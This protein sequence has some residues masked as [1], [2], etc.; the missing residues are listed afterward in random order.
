MSVWSVKKLISKAQADVMKSMRQELQ[1]TEEQNGVRFERTQESMRSMMNKVADTRKTAR[2]LADAAQA[3]AVEI[4]QNHA[5]AAK[6]EVMKTA[7]EE[8][9]NLRNDIMKEV[10]SMHESMR[11]VGPP[12][13]KEA[14]N[15]LY[16]S[17]EDHF[18]NGK[19]HK[20]VA[21][22]RKN[23]YLVFS[24]KGS[25]FK[26]KE[27]HVKN[28][29]ASFDQNGEP[30]GIEADAGWYNDY[31]KWTM[32]PVIRTVEH[33]A[34]NTGQ[35]PCHVKFSVNIREEGYANL[36]VG[37][38][39]ESKQLRQNVGIA[40][41]GLMNRKFDKEYFFVETH[42]LPWT[43][44]DIEALAGENRN[45]V[46][47]VKHH[48]DE[49]DNEQA[50]EQ[51][52]SWMKKNPDSVLV[53][54]HVGD[55]NLKGGKRFYIE[56]FGPW[57]KVTWL[58]T[59]MMQCVYKVLFDHDCAKKGIPYCKELLHA[60]AR[61][62]LSIMKV[63]SEKNLSA[64]VFVGRRTM[65]MPLMLLQTYMCSKYLKDTTKTQGPPKNLGTSS[66]SAVH[67]FRKILMKNNSTLGEFN[68][69]DET[70]AI[71]KVAGTHAHELSMVMSAVLG[72]AVDD[73]CGGP[74][75]QVFGHALYYMHH[76]DAKKPMLPDTYGT[77]S[78]LYHADEVQMVANGTVGMVKSFIELARQDSGDMKSFAELLKSHDYRIPIMAS[79]IENGRDVDKA[80]EN[81]YSTMGAGGYFGDSKKAY[82]EGSNISMAAKAVR[83]WLGFQPTKHFPVKLGDS[84]ADGKF[85]IDRTLDSGTI[86][87]EKT[88]AVN[89]KE[90][91]ISVD[92]KKDVVSVFGIDPHKRR[93]VK[94]LEERMKEFLKY[95]LMHLWHQG[96]FRYYSYGEAEPFDAQEWIHMPPKQPK[97]K[98]ALHALGPN[99]NNENM[100]SARIFGPTGAFVDHVFNMRIK[101]P[102]PDTPFWEQPAIV[103]IQE[104]SRAHTNALCACMNAAAKM[105]VPGKV[106]YVAEHGV[107]TGPEGI[108]IIYDSKKFPGGFQNTTKDG[109][110]GVVQCSGRGFMSGHL[111]RADESGIDIL[112][113]HAPNPSSVDEMK[114]LVKNAKRLEFKN[115]KGF[116]HIMTEW[117][118]NPEMWSVSPGNG[119]LLVAGDFNDAEKLYVDNEAQKLYVDEKGEQLLD[120][121]ENISIYDLMETSMKGFGK[122]Y[123]TCCSFARDK[124]TRLP[125]SYIFID[126]ESEF[127]KSLQGVVGAYDFPEENEMEPKKGANVFYQEDRK[128][129]VFVKEGE[130][131]MNYGDKTP[132]GVPLPAG[133]TKVYALTENYKDEQRRM[134]SDHK[135]LFA[136]V[137]GVG[138]VVTINYSFMLA[139]K[140]KFDATFPSEVHMGRTLLEKQ[141]EEMQNNVY[142]FQVA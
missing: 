102:H 53:Q 121:D 137:E 63:N 114:K 86:E 58:E 16:A 87:S 142:G 57:H 45:L 133:E 120:Y 71:M 44:A 4:A 33:F 55:D 14:E 110:L 27:E 43:K 73:P 37:M 113:V 54:T 9:A 98:S 22:S 112:N 106:M 25:E 56:A 99:Y 135:A 5:D 35:G 19:N 116:S 78:F 15:T 90:G 126:K 96:T 66:V 131:K 92:M 29:L 82:D 129:K 91:L 2:S 7:R 38:D 101:D 17:L 36:L 138:V 103:F 108:A 3:N 89:F 23:G 115:E 140:D 13:M 30:Q 76:V 136:K 127:D 21:F 100:V 51:A 39:E 97:L 132:F 81:K 10:A 104:S 61:C 34:E 134:Y 49:I 93:Q 74:F 119:R 141:A 77:A 80:V 47:E 28:L 48:K 31:Y 20:G 68:D 118:N 117:I 85:E 6:A 12:P 8:M 62:A 130:H 79:E 46:Q 83:V 95:R 128:G 60:M 70:F 94:E 24:H 42:Q 105:T 122:T 72:H 41:D 124:V 111:K 69:G 84:E 59:T 75:A 139:Q 11:H 26:L 50:A 67:L 1:H 125:N 18:E 107:E 88:R 64:A 123:E 40:L 65:G 109:H 32:F 52:V